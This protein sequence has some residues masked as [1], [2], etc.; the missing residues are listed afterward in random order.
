MLG[1]IF[2]AMRSR[3]IAVLP[4][5]R[6]EFLALAEARNACVAQLDAIE[7]EIAQQ[8]QT[9]GH[10]T[11]SRGLWLHALRVGRG[12]EIDALA[13][14][15]KAHQEALQ[16]FAQARGFSSAERMARVCNLPSPSPVRVRD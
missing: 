11:A 14:A 4:H 8:A 6:D 3:S 10:D 1:L 16:A 12:P 15:G 5:D 7:A 13:E 9:R 2:E